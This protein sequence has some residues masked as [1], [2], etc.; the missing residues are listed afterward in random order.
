MQP[1]KASVTSLFSAPSQY[2]IPVF[3]RGYVWSLEKQVVPLWADLEDRALKLIERSE[4][5]QQVGAQSLKPVAEALSRLVGADASPQ[6]LR[7]CYS[8]RGHRRS[9]THNYS[10]SVDACIPARREVA[11]GVTCAA[12]A[13]QLGSQ[14]WPIHSKGRSSQGLANPGGPCR[15]GFPRRSG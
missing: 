6:C 4:M 9:A 11:G 1:G 2:L 10:A 8:L 12:N 14:P 3:Q 7:P 5:A 15:D 13:R